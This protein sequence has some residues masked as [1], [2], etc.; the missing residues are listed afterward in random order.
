MAGLSFFWVVWDENLESLAWLCVSQVYPEEGH[1]HTP[2]AALGRSW[3]GNGAVP[4][5]G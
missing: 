2:K 4:I 3:A 1:T 5:P